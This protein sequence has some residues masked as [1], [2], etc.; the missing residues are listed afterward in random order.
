MYG[1]DCVM[2]FTTTEI[3]TQ[4]NSNSTAIFSNITNSCIPLM[5]ILVSYLLPQLIDS[6]GHLMQLSHCCVIDSICAFPALTIQ[7]SA[8]IE[9][10]RI[11]LSS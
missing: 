10:L 1:N 8:G 9:R 5:E 3:L 6:L 11:Y 7:M 4:H 2:R